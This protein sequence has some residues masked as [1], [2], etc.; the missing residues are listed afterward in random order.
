MS[1]KKAKKIS[2]IEVIRHGRD[3]MNLVEYPFASLWKNT[4]P[5]AEIIHEW[6]TQHPITGKMVQAI[7][8][9]TG[10]PDLGL[11]TSR[12][13][14][15]YLVL[16]ELTQEKGLVDQT[17]YFTR[18]DLLKRLRWPHNETGYDL[19]EKAFTRMGAVFITSKNAFWD[20]TARSFKTVG[21]NLIDNFEI[22]NEKP[23]RRKAGQSELPLSFF[24]WNDVLFQSFQA[25]Y[26]RAIDLDFALS[27]K[28]SLALRLYRYLDKK[29]YHGRR[30]FEI[31]LAALCERHLGMRPNR[32]PSKYKE[33]LAPAH[34]ELIARGFLESARYEAMSTKKSEKVCYAFAPRQSRELPLSGNIAAPS[35]TPSSS[36]S[37]QDTDPEAAA[38]VDADPAKSL[39]TADDDLL[40]RMLALKISPEVARTL[41]NSASAEQ[42]TL[43][44][45]CLDARAPQ[46]AAA[47]FVKAVRESWEPP[48]KY[49]KA[50]AAAERA[51]KTRQVREMAQTEK[52]VQQA[53]AR[54]QAAAHD[55]EAATLNAMWDK[56][57]IRT[58]E[59][60]EHQVREKLASNEFLCAR[61]E[62]GKLTPSSPDWIQTR[63]TI[64]REMLGK[65]S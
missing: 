47:V 16:M 63:H 27:L 29:S 57:D 12:D 35:V 52:A 40:E 32:Y 18:H 4:E 45:D 14:Q 60:L 6:E 36:I 59:R 55:Q 51:Q 28:G 62:A 10:D 53:E 23:G 31:E 34:E 26:I 21:F 15:L 43:Q 56:L 8:R 64:L 17:V 33:R 11:P 19:L 42:L 41:L 65:I 61:L 25:G 3:E 58:Q 37:P 5:G 46:D 50:L 38:P 24:K 2:R 44:L 7:W 54:K 13:E 39:A 49:L 9:V 1:E 48:A 20:A 22:F 30:T